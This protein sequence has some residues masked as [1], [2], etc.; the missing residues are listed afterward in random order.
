MF[1]VCGSDEEIVLGA[2]SQFTKDG[3]GRLKAFLQ[4]VV[5]SHHSDDELL[6]MWNEAE[7][8]FYLSG[9]HRIRD[10]YRK[11]ISLI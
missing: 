6:A 4:T 9:A 10:F 8:D 11:I 5:D 7:S 1:E 2:L 3:Q